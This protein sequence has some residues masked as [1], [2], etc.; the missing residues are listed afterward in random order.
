MKNKIQIILI[1]IILSICSYLFICNIEH[2][3]YLKTTTYSYDFKVNKD[4][5]NIKQSLDNTKSN[6][7]KMDRLKNSYL[8]INE[9][10]TIKES[11]QANVN[12]AEKTNI[13]KYK[14]KEVKMNQV[15]LYHFLYDTTNIGV[16]PIMDEY[17]LIAKY[18]K[19]L[20]KNS[21]ADYLLNLLISD[22]EIWGTL[23]D[24]YLYRE[25]HNSE[26]IT[27]MEIL[28]ILS[29][30]TMKVHT[31]E[32]ISNLVLESGDISE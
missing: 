31:M 27:N 23:R 7:L 20:N 19:T 15:G 29:N 21:F 25:N 13:W 9:I 14:D 28:E 5:E 26:Y 11:L 32:Y 8:S 4:I 10:S 3:I 16:N 17:S 18:N 24:N 6:I 30:F 22:S 2:I 12:L 1:T